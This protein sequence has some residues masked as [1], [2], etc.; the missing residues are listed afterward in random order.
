MKLRLFFYLSLMIFISCIHT[1]QTNQKTKETATHVVL[2]D[3]SKTVPELVNKN[4]NSEFSFKFD[5][6]E[7]SN[8]N[9][10]TKLTLYATQYYIFKANNNG[11]IPLLDK[12]GEPLGYK[13]D[14]CDWCLAAIEGTM[15]IKDQ[16][17]K[18]IVLNYA[19]NSIEMQVD[20]NLCKKLKNYQNKSIGKSL[21]A[22]SSGYGDGVSGCKLI[23]YRTIAVDKTKIP[24]GSVVFIPLAK[25]VTI[26]LPDGTTAIHDG[27]FF[28]GDKGGDINNNHI[29]V[30]TGL[31]STNPFPEIIKSNSLKTFAA[32]LIKDTVIIND[33]IKLH[34]TFKLNN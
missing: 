21:W 3:T 30:F 24:Y 34:K 13:L 1:S 31:T 5:Y 25:G 15:F 10:L 20:C 29:D 27:Y 4:Q 17:G 12:N 14:T 18:N 11:T 16:N 22:I 6:T 23:P 26:A 19:G 7:P 28:A 32:Y 9:D 33:L 2:S 8:L